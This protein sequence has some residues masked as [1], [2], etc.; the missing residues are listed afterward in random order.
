MLFRRTL[1]LV[2]LVD[3][4]VHSSLFV[5]S[6]PYPFDFSIVFYSFRRRCCLCDSL[7]FQG[8]PS[9]SHPVLSVC[10]VNSTVDVV[11]RRLS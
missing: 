8:L 10:S 4:T 2:V 7:R 3:F 5:P 6:V 1:L 11:G 9:Y